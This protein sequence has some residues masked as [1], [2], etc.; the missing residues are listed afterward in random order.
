MTSNVWKVEVIISVY[1]IVQLLIRMI[2]WVI[3]LG[4]SG[5]C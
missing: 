1:S 5:W 2:E 3:K 4:L